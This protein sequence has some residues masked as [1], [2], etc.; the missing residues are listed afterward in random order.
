[1]EPGNIK[2]LVVDDEEG[3]RE[4]LREYLAL[5]GYEVDAVCS[6]EKAIEAGI[7]NYDLLLLDVMMD[8]MGGFELA[9]HMKKNE[10][11]ARVPVIFLT[12]RD[13]DDDVVEGLETGAYDYISKPFSMKV[14]IARIGA[15]LRRCDK[16]R[17]VV[18]DRQ[19]LIC[20]VDDT[21]VKLP[22]KEFELLA[23]MLE[24][25]GRIFKREELLKQVW[26]EN[27]V[28]VDRSVDV[29]ITRIRSKLGPYARNIVSRSGYGYG[30]QD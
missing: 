23:F 11:T 5:E 20:R 16:T 4:G 14:L 17:G 18:C 22:R 3:I 10:A 19:T 9:R 21:V 25:R 12:A 13:S 27:V 6:A 15:V 7:E 24:N 26:P 1:M 28:V 30:W 8:G 2:L 29:H